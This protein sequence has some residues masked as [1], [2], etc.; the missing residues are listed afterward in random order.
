MGISP[1]STSQNASF[2]VS[3]AGSAIPSDAASAPASDAFAVANAS[4]P[5]LLHSLH[6]FID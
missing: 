1:A 3:T 5:V 4:V 2:N 6:L